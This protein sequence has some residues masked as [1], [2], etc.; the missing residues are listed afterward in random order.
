MPTTAQMLAE[1]PIFLLEVLAELRSADVDGVRTREEAIAQLAPQLADPTNVQMAYQDVVDDRP[2]A[3]DAVRLLLLEH[4]ELAEAQFSRQFGAIRHMGPAKLEREAP[5]LNPESIAELLYYYG[6]IG[7]GY[8][9]AGETAHTIIYLPSD[10]TPWLPHP[11]SEAAASGLPVKP[12]TPPSLARQML[13]DDSFL[14]DAGTLLGFVRSERLRLTPQGPHP[15]DVDRLV[16]RFI[17]PFRSDEPDLVVRLAL[18]LHLANRMG[19]LRRDGDVV[20]LTGNRVSAFLDQPRAAQRQALFEAWRD[21]PEWNDLC[22]TPGLECADTGSWKNDPLQ[23]RS[24]LLRL[25]G[26][27][28]PGY[29]YTQD[30]LVRAIRTVEPDFQRPTGNY[31][32]WYIRNNSTNEFLK[33]FEQWGGVEGVLIRFLLRGPLYW[34]NVIDLA[35]PAAG[36]NLLLSLGPWGARWLGHNTP[37][38]DAPSQQRIT[39]AEDFTVTVP[40]ATPLADRFRVERFAEWQRSYPDY[41]YR[42]TQRTLRR[43]T[44][45]GISVAQIRQFLAGQDRQA[46]PRVLAALERFAAGDNV[47]GG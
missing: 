18:L 2:E 10:I 20:R 27:L 15:E 37:Q 6:L 32:T 38:P 9:G 22:R 23:T 11:Q 33:G 45:D 29:W 16:Q 39:V 4:G 5:W 40:Q 13:A 42:I 21:S 47:Q 31:D 24:A 41:V 43:A 12:V 35:E 36:D 46:P 26:Q 7:R 3:E 14:N 19:W 17:L 30:D 1:Y 28:A 44:D 25:I 34:L 8:K